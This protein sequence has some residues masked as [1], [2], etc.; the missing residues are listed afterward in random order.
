[1]GRDGLCL[2]RRLS[3]VEVVDAVGLVLSQPLL[4]GIQVGMG[5]AP[6]GVLA[7]GRAPHGPDGIVIET[8]SIGAVDQFRDPL[9]G[10]PLGLLLVW[11]RWA[12]LDGGGRGGGSVNTI[13]QPRSD[14]LAKLYAGLIDHSVVQGA[15]AG[16]GDDEIV[17]LI[18]V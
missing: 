7:R 11:R 2:L 6:H 17:L 12:T 14:L 10:R 3:S 8:G 9:L 5:C 18:H 1:L 15:V 4:E 16:L 13:L